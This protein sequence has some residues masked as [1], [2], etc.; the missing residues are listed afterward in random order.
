MS[1]VFL[2]NKGMFIDFCRTLLGIVVKL[3]YFLHQ[4]LFGLCDGLAL[5]KHKMYI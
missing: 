1:Q 4:E 5:R 2:P 3:H